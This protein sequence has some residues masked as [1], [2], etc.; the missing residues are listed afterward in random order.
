MSGGVGGLAGAIPLAR[1][2]PGERP[3]LAAEGSLRHGKRQL[4]INQASLVDSGLTA[5]SAG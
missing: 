3:P 1:P 5:T 4:A 2:D